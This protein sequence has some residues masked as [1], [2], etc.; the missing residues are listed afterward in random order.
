M[1][2]GRGT[3]IPLLP[4]EK[5]LVDAPYSYCRNPMV[6][7]AIMFYFGLCVFIGS[8]DAF[9]IVAPVAVVLLVYAKFWEEG[10]LESRFGQPYIEYKR[11]TPFLIPKIFGKRWYFLFLR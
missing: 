6:L 9:Y 8:W 10:E 11:H 4:P 1:K 7:G 5:L 2:R 3:P